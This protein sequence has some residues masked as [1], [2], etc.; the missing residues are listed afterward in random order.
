MLV[1]FIS[2]MKKRLHFTRQRQS[3]DSHPY[4]ARSRALDISLYDCNYTAIAGM[5]LSNPRMSDWTIWYQSLNQYSWRNRNPRELLN[6][7]T[8]PWAHLPDK[9]LR[10]HIPSGKVSLT[11]SPEAGRRH[12]MGWRRR[13]DERYCIRSVYRRSPVSIMQSERRALASGISEKW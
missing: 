13:S 6:I 2:L 9:A 11:T 12:S 1:S 5:A 3:M 8:E 7:P 4:F 10:S